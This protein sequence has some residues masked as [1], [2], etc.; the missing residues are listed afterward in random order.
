[1]CPV[2]GTVESGTGTMD[3]SLLMGEP[4]H[5]RKTSGS[6]AISGALNEDSAPTIVADNSRSIHAM[7]ESC[8]VIQRAEESPPEN[9]QAGRSSWRFLYALCRSYRSH[10]MAV[11]WSV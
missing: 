5:I 9:S 6:H 2:D 10:R 7:R 8:R 4:F 1:M 11:E 3:E